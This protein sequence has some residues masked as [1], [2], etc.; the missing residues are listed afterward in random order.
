MNEIAPI[1]T[2]DRA[3]AVIPEQPQTLLAAIVA[4]AKDPS[5]D[6]QKLDALL[7]MQE[8]LEARQAEA[9]FNTALRDAQAIMPRVKKNGTID[10]GGKGSI[11]F[12]TWEDVDTVLRP[13]MVQH[14]FSISFDTTARDGGGAGISA[15]LRHA[16]GHAK[17][18]S[19]PLPLDSGPGRNNLQAMGS[20]LSYGKRYLAEMLFNI[21]RTGQDDDGKYGGTEFI[22]HDQA[23]QLDVLITETGSDRAKFLETFQLAHMLNMDQPTFTRALNMLNAKKAR[24]G[25]G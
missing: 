8:R 21:V 13:I 1:S 6:V 10:L 11:P 15:T 17:T 7:A 12:A 4:M 19:I 18:V 3:P 16:A 22:S 5:V 14:G 24:M 9:E 23:K 20:T 25:R 2:A